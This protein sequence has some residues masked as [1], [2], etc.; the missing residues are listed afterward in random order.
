MSNRNGG[1]GPGPRTLDGCSVELY[2]A[3]AHMGEAEVIHAALPERAAILELGAGAGRVTHPLVALGH[4]VT[5]VDFSPEMLAEIHGADTVVAD[6]AN[7]RLTQRFEGVV[8]GS[9]LINVPGK[10]DRSAFLATCAYHLAAHGTALFECHTR[11][12][13][14]RAVPGLLGEEPNGI[15]ISWLDVRAHGDLVTGTLEYQA[16]DRRWT[17]TFSTRLLDELQ[18][19]EALREVGLCFDGWLNDR[20]SWFAAKRAS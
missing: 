3:L 2:K 7:L 20:H 6:I 19:R 10:D 12:L 13:L 5:A 8:L 11:S 18:I 14:E 16:G 15:R 1:T 17:Q 9:T 4:P